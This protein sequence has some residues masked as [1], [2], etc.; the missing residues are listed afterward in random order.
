M[1]IVGIGTDIVSVSRIRDV[2][3]QYP[4]RFP[5]KI[6]HPQERIIYAGIKNKAAFLA[7]RFV[8]KEAVAKALGSGFSNGIYAAGIFIHNNKQ[9]Q[10]YVQ[11]TQETEMP[12]QEIMISIA[13]E[14]EYAVAYAIA[15]RRDV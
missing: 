8:A 1:K 6:L 11:L 4:V 13:D 5:R 9:G 15:L 2:L 7:K 12:I 10:P 3:A 14:R